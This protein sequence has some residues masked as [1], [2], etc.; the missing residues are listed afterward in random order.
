MGR[1]GILVSW[2]EIT[3]VRPTR[4][5]V[6]ENLAPFS[7]QQI[8]LGLAR[9]S[10]QLSTWRNSASMDSDLEAA[11]QTLPSYYR[12][13]K[14]LKDA[15]RDRVIL[16][17]ANILYVAKQALHACSLEGRGISGPSDI[18]RVM[19]C[20]LMAN[21]LLLPKNASPQDDILQHAVG[22]LPFYSYIPIS[23]DPLKSHPI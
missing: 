15:D 21:D 7:L 19:S 5:M 2:H 6:H 18:E 9:L 3:G 17:R 20:C 14:N 1:L 22:Y 10:A 8:L 16:T 23:S 11:R 4:Q 13:I 12:A